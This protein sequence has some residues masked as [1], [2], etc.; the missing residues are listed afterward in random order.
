MSILLNSGA[1]LRFKSFQCRLLSRPSRLEGIAELSTSWA[2]MTRQSPQY[3]IPRPDV[4]VYTQW[5]RNAGVAI[6]HI[7]ERIFTQTLLAARVSFV[8]E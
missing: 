2:M 7:F 6:T 4:D 3:L 1:S 5:R 8:R